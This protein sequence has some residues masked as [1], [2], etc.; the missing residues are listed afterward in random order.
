M[1]V[2]QVFKVMGSAELMQKSA[3]EENRSRVGSGEGEVCGLGTSSK[4]LAK[5]PGLVFRR[6]WRDYHYGREGRSWIEVG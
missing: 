3:K 6:Y 4:L 5:N 2:S 1:P